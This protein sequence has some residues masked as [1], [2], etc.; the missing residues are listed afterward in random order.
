[1]LETLLDLETSQRGYLLT[2]ERP[3]LEPYRQAQARLDADVSMLTEL[4][5]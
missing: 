5:R 1:M 3:Y 4:A 2:L